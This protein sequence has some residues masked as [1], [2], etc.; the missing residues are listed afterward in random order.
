MKKNRKKIYLLLI[1]ILLFF[2]STMTY[3]SYKTRHIQIS[4][5]DLASIDDGT[6][7]GQYSM[8]PVNVKTKVTVQNHRIIKIEIL[9]Y[10]NGLGSKAEKIV[11]RVIQYQS[12][13]ADT[14][15]GATVSSKCILKSIENALGGNNNE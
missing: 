12:L 7:T 11:D 3:I 2:I 9:K 15:S 5:I 8:I 14:V 1:I 10:D 13:E 6:Y 4:D